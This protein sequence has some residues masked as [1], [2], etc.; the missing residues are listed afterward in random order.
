MIKEPDIYSAGMEIMSSAAIDE[1][2]RSSRWPAIP[3]TRDSVAATC[4]CAALR[5]SS[6]ATSTTRAARGVACCALLF[7][8]EIDTLAPKRSIAARRGDARTR[9]R[10][11]RDTFP[12]TNP[13][14]MARPKTTPRSQS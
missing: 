10:H 6:A 11:R 2:R 1:A 12:T 5:G 13:T 14:Q 9:V 3:G 8:D 7:L 4:L